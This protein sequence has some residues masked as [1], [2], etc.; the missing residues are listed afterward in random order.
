MCN[1]SAFFFST[2]LNFSKIIFHIHTLLTIMTNTK[3]RN[4]NTWVEYSTLGFQ[5]AIYMVLG[6]W[7]GTAIDTEESKPLWTIV[8]LLLGIILGM[9]NFFKTVLKKNDRK[10]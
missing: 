4:D 7:A 6:L 1:M 3:K 10:K 8:F 2:I 5:I 9:Y